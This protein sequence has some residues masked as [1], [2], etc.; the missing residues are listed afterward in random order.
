[1]A[2][3]LRLFLAVV[4]GFIVGS[5]VN[6]A[7]VMVSGKLIP[8]PAG[9][10]V[11]TLEGLKASLHLFE[12]KHFVIP[13]LAHALGTLVGAL[14]AALLSPNRATAPAYVVGVVFLLGGIANIFMIGSPVW[15]NAIDVVFAYLPMAW[16]GLK[17]AH[18]LRPAR[19]T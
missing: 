12:P 18:R 3:F 10:D 4:I 19:S 9:A 16:L 14:V 11:T 15:F 2:N 5:I 8:P 13:F 7:L 1:M 6:M 17:A